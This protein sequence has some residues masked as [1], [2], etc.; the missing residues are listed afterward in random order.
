VIIYNHMVVDTE[1]SGEQ[2]DRLFRA[3]ADATRRDIV[4]RAAR[5]ELSVS[6]LARNYDMSI[7]A[8]QKH[9][10]VLERAGLVS[11]HKEGR[12]QLVHTRPDALATARDVLADI[13]QLWLA[14]L[15]QFR[16]T[17]AELPP[18]GDER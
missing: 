14:R 1:L 11:K 4:A 18:P 9:V 17:L 3:L 8:V 12:E 16:D 7:T 10:R 13:E 6:A 15:T 2:I 5:G